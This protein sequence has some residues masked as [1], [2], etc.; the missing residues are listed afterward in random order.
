VWWK[1]AETIV[2]VRNSTG[3]PYD[4]AMVPKEE[5]KDLP[6]GCFYGPFAR[7]MANMDGMKNLKSLI[8][9]AEWEAKQEI[10]ASKV[11]EYI[12]AVEFLSEYNYLKNRYTLS[13]KKEDIRMALRK[14]GI[15]QGDLI[16]VHSGLSS[17]G[18]IEGGADTVIDAFLEVVGDKGTLL[19]PTFTMS[20]T[21]FN[22]D[23][24]AIRNH[25][26]F[27]IEDTSVW[28]GK[29]PSTF[30]KR[31]GVVRSSHPTHSVAGIGHLA[32]K[33]LLAHRASDPPVCR[34]SPFG[35]LMECNGKIAWFGAGLESTTFF[36]LLENELDMPYLKEAVCRVKEK[37]GAIRILLIQKHLPGHRDFY[38][39]PAEGTKMY[40]E[41]L[42]KG[43]VIDK[44]NLGFG[45]IKV[46]DAK[47]MYELGM[48]SLKKEPTLLLCDNPECIFCSKYKNTV[49]ETFMRWKQP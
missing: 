21:C 45:E 3:L 16:M 35:K 34:N 13:I 6:D 46:I 23:C 4:L 39:C 9:E 29:I 5:R 1:I 24:S 33:C 12:G 41:L 27:D 44:S 49:K 47:Q 15:R 8:L 11:R 26:P 18:H 17:F 22:G 48:E 20:F 19:F 2:P 40:K 36:H 38:I 43:L 37:T 25:R 28:V 14:A 7:I 42:K 10:S 30:L 31:K 32:G